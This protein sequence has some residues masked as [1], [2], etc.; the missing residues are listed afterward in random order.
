MSWFSGV[1]VYLLLW[2][3]V[4]FAVLPFGVQP[5]AHGDPAAGGWRGAPRRPLLFRKLVA[6][7]LV[8][9][10]LWI[11]I[12]AVIESGWLSLRSGWLAMPER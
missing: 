9:A 8:A 7:T 2:W 6:T 1:V 12:H 3:I 10:L 5:E 11:V 4:L